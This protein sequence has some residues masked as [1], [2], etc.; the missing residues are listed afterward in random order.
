MTCGLIDPAH[1]RWGER[2][3]RIGR[4]ALLQPRAAG[5][6]GALAAWA[7][8][9]LVPKVMV[10]TQT[11]VIEAAADP[12]GRWLPVVPVI[13]VT[14][15]VTPAGV[16]V[17]AILAVLLAPAVSAHARRTHAGAA[18]SPDAIK[19][20]ARQVA[21]LPL[22]ADRSAWDA[23]AGAARAASAAAASADGAGW[24]A[25]LRTLGAAMGDAYGCD[26]SGW[27]WDRIQRLPPP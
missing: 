6:E 22:P 24:L 11:R 13:S 25:A 16:D 27:W 3:A 20:S 5:L 23:G 2:A 8:R 4:R 18:L 12:D 10:A 19:L 15:T 17:W 26:V 1:V 21:A 14:P 9:R 7:R